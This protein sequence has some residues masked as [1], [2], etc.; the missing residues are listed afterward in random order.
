MSQKS[1]SKCII[2]VS[3]EYPPRRLTKTSDKIK[4][5]A[6]FLS[7]NKIKT[8]VITFDDWRTDNVKVN[9]YLEVRRVPYRVTSNISF[10][11]MIMNLKA[12]YQSAIAS[13]LHDQ[14][15]DIIHVFDWNCLVPLIPWREKIK[16]KILYSTSSIQH[17]RDPTINPYNNGI[18]EIERLGLKLANKIITKD[19][20]LTEE[21]V[22]Q[23]NIEKEKIDVLAVKSRNYSKKI[24]QTY[25]EILTR[26]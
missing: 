2:I 24:L 14:K 9:E 11:A 4:D 19:N 22:E 12:S 26:K 10:L 23:Y 7:D 17:T 25:Q 5:L 13:V 6:H 3:F 1:K 18:K 8:F 21:I 20:N 16:A 15:V